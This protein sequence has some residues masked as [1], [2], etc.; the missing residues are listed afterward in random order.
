[1]SAAELPP[2]Q[3]GAK[4]PLEESERNTAPK[5]RQM[6]IVLTGG[7]CSGKSSILALLRDRLSKRGYQVVLVPEYATHFF[8]NSDGFQG[9]WVATD[10]EKALQ[11][12]LLKYQM[13]QEDLFKDYAALNSKP[14]VFILDRGTLDQKVF[15]SSEDIWTTALTSCGVTETELL[16]RYDMVMHLGTCAKA[17]EYEWGPGS[18]NPARYHSPEEAAKLDKVCEEVYKDH[19]QLRVVPHCTKFEDKVEQV[20]YYL[21]DA[22]GVD[23]LSGTRHRVEVKLQGDIPSEVL[24]QSQAFQITAAFLDKALQ[25]C[26]RRKLRVPVDRVCG[27]LFKTTDSPANVAGA[28]TPRGSNLCDVDPTFEERRAIPDEAFLARRT[29]TETAYNN[30]LKLS[31]GAVVDE[32]VLSFQTSS[33]LHYELLYFR[34]LHDSHTL[35]LDC[36]VGAALPVW[37][38]AIVEAKPP[39]PVESSFRVF[40]RHST[41]EAA[42]MCMLKFESNC[43]ASVKAGA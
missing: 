25:L 38:E 37:L 21:E 5:P 32:H 2:A 6:T 35:L 30:S 11:R 15:V 1:M 12:V 14:S 40:Q 17:G 16:A 4:R 34:G 3:R 28:A 41:A 9:E 27:G 24:K 20:M 31:L 42:Y 7:P 8:V 26:V 36:T 19:K 43:R 18:K 39:P 23:G 33:G 29:I 13:M 22:L 10:K